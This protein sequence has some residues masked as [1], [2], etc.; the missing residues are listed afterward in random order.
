MKKTSSNLDVG[1]K[2]RHKMLERSD[3]QESLSRKLR[4]H[5]SQISRVL[6]GDFKRL[7]PH[8]RRLCEYAGLSLDKLEAKP[9]VPPA[10]KLLAEVNNLW[11][12]T[13]GHEKALLRVVKAIRQLR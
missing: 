12:G 5:Q 9:R 4:I 1:L 13:P 6:R 11:D 8:V 10:G 7:S 3:T 2:I